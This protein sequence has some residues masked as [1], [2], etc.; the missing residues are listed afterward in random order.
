MISFDYCGAE[1]GF[2]IFLICLT[3]LCL[4]AAIVAFLSKKYEML[5]CSNRKGYLEG[6]IKDLG[7]HF[8]PE[9]S[10]SAVVLWR[11]YVLVC[12]HLGYKD[13]EIMGMLSDLIPAPEQEVER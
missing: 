8:C 6:C 7:N 3:F 1:I 13:H 5:K 4:C 10:F 9:C 12:T 11:E 2:Y